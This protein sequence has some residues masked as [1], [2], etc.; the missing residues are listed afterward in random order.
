M[1]YK[2]KYQE[3]EKEAA[4]KISEYNALDKELAQINGFFDKDLIERKDK[5]YKEWQSAQLKFE[6]FK[7]FIK[8]D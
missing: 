5:A 8:K 6:D 1:D 2:E 4:L 7:S 3:L